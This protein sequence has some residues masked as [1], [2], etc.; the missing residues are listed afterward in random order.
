MIDATK[1]EL[2]NVLKNMKG[3]HRVT[4][5]IKDKVYA[6]IK[7]F[8][9][10]DDDDTLWTMKLWSGANINKVQGYWSTNINVLGPERD[11]FTA[12]ARIKLAEGLKTL[13]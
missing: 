5:K 4:F 13:L 3:A 6:I 10:E 1:L 2:Y 7:F 9:D 8:D 11:E 12:K